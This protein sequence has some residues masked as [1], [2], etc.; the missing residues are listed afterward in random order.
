ME[1][2]WREMKKNISL[3]NR[4]NKTDAELAEFHTDLKA[5]VSTSVAKCRVERKR[6]VEA[7]HVLDLSDS[8]MRR[9]AKFT[10]NLPLANYNGILHLVP[11]LVNVVTVRLCN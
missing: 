7:A 6:K 5:A 10:D 9:A 4:I 1:D 2:A 3:S 11:R 8:S